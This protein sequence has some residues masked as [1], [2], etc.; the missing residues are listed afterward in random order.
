MVASPRNQLAVLN[1]QHRPAPRGRL[2]LLGKLSRPRVPA[3]AGLPWRNTVAP[4]AR[5]RRRS[6]ARNDFRGR[7]SPIA[8]IR[9]HHELGVTRCEEAHERPHPASAGIGLQAF[10]SVMRMI[11]TALL[12]LTTCSFVPLL[13]VQA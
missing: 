5:V 2:L 4:A 10:R 11:A 1:Q 6:R 13:Q 8:S 9:T 7:S 3:T 12:S